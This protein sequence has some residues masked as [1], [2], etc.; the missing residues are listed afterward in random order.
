M[1]K[2]LSFHNEKVKYPFLKRL[3][4]WFDDQDKFI[5]ATFFIT[6]ILVISTPVIVSSYLLI[7]QNAAPL[8]YS[9]I[10]FAPDFASSDLI[11]LFNQPEK[12]PLARSRVRVFAWYNQQLQTTC[13]ICGPNTL[14][15]LS[16]ANA[17]SKL[18]QW[19]IEQAIEVDV[20]KWH[21]CTADKTA[22]RTLTYINTIIQ[23]GGSVSYIGM[24]EPYLG[25]QEAIPGQSS[26]GQTMEQTAIQTADFMSRIK[27]A[28][29][30]IKVGDI[31]PYPRFSFSQLKLWLIKL[32][33]L[34][35]K[36]AF[37]HLDV[38]RGLYSQD[39]FTRDAADF[40]IFLKERG[41][42]FGVVLWSEN[43]AT[44]KEYYD[45]VM[46]WA[47]VVKSAVGLTEQTILQSWSTRTTTGVLD[48]P[49]N[50]PENDPNVFSH[51]RLINDVWK[52]IAPPDNPPIGNH[53]VST[54][55]VTGGWTCDQEDYNQALQVGFF[56]DGQAGLGGTFL[57]Y[58]TANKSRPDVANAG[59]CGGNQNTGFNFTTPAS[60]RDGKPHTIYAYPIN[61]GSSGINPLMGGSP[62]TITCAPKT[63]PE[64]YHDVS[65]CNISG[66]WTCD[67]DDYNKSINV[68]FYAD[69]PAGGGGRIIGSTVANVSRPDLITA[70][71]CGK[72]ADHGFNFKTPD[73]LK[74]GKPHSI[75]AY[76]INIG[77]GLENPLLGTSPKTV[78]C[79]VPTPTFTPTPTPIPNIAKGY[80]DSLSCSVS[81]G[82]ACDED[83]YSQPLDI[84]FYKDG[85]AGEGG[86][87]IGKATAN[88]QREVAV[89]KVCGGNRSHGFSFAIP[90]SLKDGTS[91]SIYAYAINIGPNAKNPLLNLSP[92]TIT[93]SAPTSTPTFTPTPTLTP[94]TIPT[95]TPTP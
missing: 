29:P 4:D 45:E 42:P 1:P 57:G 23:R 70:G 72:T 92:R 55:E 90:Q 31:E 74:D 78:N 7:R 71:V 49:I 60:L 59:F 41:I 37:F 33:S 89:G 54:C 88:L 28:Y 91:H 20:I 18:K 17:F 82:W 86:I 66:G 34:G 62:K 52:L 65:N 80:H 19:G 11:N 46:N 32:E 68:H 93:C 85:P 84:H 35:Q 8:A 9:E 15:N 43:R 77:N 39:A 95:S 64:G 76:A 14:N 6:A 53:D 73:S 83:N 30:N 67:P 10:W 81:A 48:I 40:K 56:A 69:G 26:C 47:G 36:P 94:T 22:P 38:N 27:K 61:I 24:D 5:K 87:F 58:A 44:D 79:S 50:L 21:S 25:G 3:K 75:Y 13:S 63:K 16:S 12:W 2:I 51:T